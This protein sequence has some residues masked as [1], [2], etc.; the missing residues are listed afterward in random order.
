MPYAK[1]NMHYS[2]CF[3]KITIYLSK[4][5]KICMYNKYRTVEIFFF[6]VKRR[7]T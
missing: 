3:L 2:I 6:L 5:K 7:E 4:L 1:K